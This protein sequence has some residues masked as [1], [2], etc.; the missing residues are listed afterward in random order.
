M[1]FH[2]NDFLFIIDLVQ[3]VGKMRHEVNSFS[4]GQLNVK[5]GSNT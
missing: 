1:E 2:Y 4:G 5:R 3:N